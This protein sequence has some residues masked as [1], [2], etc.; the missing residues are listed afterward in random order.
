MIWLLIWFS[1]IPEIGIRYHYLGDFGNETLCRS[2]LREASVL[3]NSP[4]ETIKC[5]GVVYV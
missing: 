3:V 2:A 5:I 1:V 4:T